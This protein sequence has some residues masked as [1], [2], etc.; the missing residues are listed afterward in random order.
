LVG[1]RERRAMN[2]QQKKH[3]KSK[4]MAEIERNAAKDVFMVEPEVKVSV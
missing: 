3:V 1:N 4:V 2:E